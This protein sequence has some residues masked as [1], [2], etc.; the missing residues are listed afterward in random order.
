[1]TF[2]T[3]QAGLAGRLVF[4][5]PSALLSLVTLRLILRS[6][7]VVTDDAV[8][9]RHFAD[10]KTKRVPRTGVGGV[11][12]VERKPRDVR[13]GAPSARQRRV[14]PIAGHRRL[15]AH[16]ARRLDVVALRHAAPG[17][18]PSLRLILRKLDLG[19]RTAL[20]VWHTTR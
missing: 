6:S 3:G 12:L 7:V 2:D 13:G 20:A 19:S 9:V 15:R 16:T 5:V 17:H 14:R 11:D 10:P 4:A 1:M 8:L 18:S